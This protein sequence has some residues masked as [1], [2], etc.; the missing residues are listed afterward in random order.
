[1]VEFSPKPIPGAWRDGFA[2]DRHTLSSEFLGYN[3]YGNPEYDTTRTEI[4]EQLFRLK[5]RG[6][7]SA[8]PL[9]VDAAVQFFESWA[10]DI[11]LLIPVPPSNEQRKHQPV[12]ALARE[13]SKRLEIELC[14]ACVRKTKQT[15]ELKSVRFYAERIDILK[16]AFDMDRTKVEKRKVLLFDDLFRSGATLNAITKALY[17]QGGAESVYALAV[18]KTRSRS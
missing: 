12:I 5:Y 3:E 7:Q 4:G 6:D 18:T 8:I 10:P 17:N 16:D 9:I 14:D 11:D 15:E 2:L 1:M 13:L